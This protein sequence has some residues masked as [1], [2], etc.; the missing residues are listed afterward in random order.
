[1]S[2]SHARKSAG[3]G[4]GADDLIGAF[5]KRSPSASRSR[6]TSLSRAA[7]ALTALSDD[8]LKAFAGAKS[9][10][11][12]LVNRMLAQTRT[13]TKTPERI[14]LQGLGTP[15]ISEGEGLGELLSEEEGRRRLDAYAKPS[16]LKDW[17]G[18]TAGPVEI[19][20]ALKIPRST[21]HQWQRKG[22]VIGLL[23]GV[24]KNV[25]PLE[26]FVD[27]KPVAGIAEVMAI[28]DHPRITW[29]W[30]KT[31]HPLLGGAKPLTRLKQG[32]Q[33]EVLRAAHTNFGQ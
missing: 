33:D 30:M 8:Q 24:R 2:T 1:M 17:A 14:S 13:E 27:G 5:A 25:F 9:R 22:L 23:N 26:Q 12:D 29:R 28:I 6:L 10:L 7:A 18:P 4:G 31:P 19:E 3:L 16:L 11:P 15:E 21:L 20:R 32:R